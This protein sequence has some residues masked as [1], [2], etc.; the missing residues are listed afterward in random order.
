[1]SV[2]EE[3]KPEI[4]SIKKSVGQEYHFHYNRDERLKLKNEDGG[5]DGKKSRR[6]KMTKWLIVI[7]AAAIGVLMLLLTVRLLN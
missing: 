5:K 3:E 2:G 1:M 4:L 6:R 7:L